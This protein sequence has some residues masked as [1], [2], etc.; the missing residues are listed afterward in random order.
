MKTKRNHEWNET[1]VIQIGGEKSDFCLIL[2]CFVFFAQ[3]LLN[4][5]LAQ[6]TALVMLH[7]K[8]KCLEK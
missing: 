7:L 4:E 6:V 5:H 8:N 2:N 3:M 1:M